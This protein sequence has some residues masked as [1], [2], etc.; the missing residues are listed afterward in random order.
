MTD[1]YQTRA[2]QHDLVIF[3][4]VEDSK[5]GKV[6]GVPG[7]ARPREKGHSPRRFQRESRNLDKW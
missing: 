7:A 1:T 6:S 2:L 3:L 5:Q 4:S